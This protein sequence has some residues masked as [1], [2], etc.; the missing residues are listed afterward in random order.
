VGWLTVAEPG[1]LT[2]V[3]DLGR[4]GHTSIGVPCGGAFDALSLRAGNRLL[5][6]ADD[7][8]GLEITLVGPTLTF[9]TATAFALTGAGTARGDVESWVRIPVRAGEQ[10]RIGPIAGSARAYLCVAGGLRVPTR[11]GSASTLL[12]AGF[13]GHAGRALRKGDRLEF[14]D[15]ASGLPSNYVPDG[16]REPDASPVGVRTIR[17]VDGPHSS[18]FDPREIGAFWSAAFAVSNQSNRTG[19]RLDGPTIGSRTTGDMTSEGS[20]PGGVQITPAGH[21]IVL[22]VDHPTT[23]GYPIIATV[24]TVDFHLLGRAKPG[25]T[26]RFVRVGR[27]Q[28]LNALQDRERAWRR[29]EAKP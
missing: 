23:G 22:G 29:N 1:M 9:E 24:A 17:A 3:Q 5:G 25:D 19:V 27:S 8:A 10:V 6:N 15:E 12:S 26:V 21:P 7:A 13:G 4:E 11:L 20:P 18:G 28:A 2:T 14:G 16:A